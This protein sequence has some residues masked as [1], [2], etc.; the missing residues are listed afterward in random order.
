MGGDRA[1]AVVVEGAVRAAQ[2]ASG[3][4]QVLLFGPEARLRAELERHEAA[5]S[6]PIQIADAPE[7]IGMGEAPAAAVKNKR[8]SS[9]HLGLGAHQAGEADAFVSAG[10]TGAVM[11][12]S[13]FILGRL[14][15]V[16][17]PAVI[18]YYPTTRSFCIVLDV[19]TN[20]D[21]KPEHL[22]Q[23]AQMGSVYAEQVMKRERPAVALM[24]IGE[25]PGKGNE[26]VKAAFE[27]LQEEPGLN[28]RGN[29]EGRDL[30]HHAADVVVCDGFVGNVM[31]KL[32]ESMTTALTEMVRQEMERQR[33][34]E[35]ERAVVARVLGGVQKP[36]NYEEFGGAPLLGVGGNVLIGH[37][38]SSARAVERMVLAAAE[39]A[40]QDVA[41]SIA[42]ALC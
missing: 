14:P 17:R 33:L 10:N 40:Q 41:G 42:A 1:P 8:R 32:G 23:F 34:S 19:G 12:A 39:V 6:L 3:A 7:T 2:E 38:G 4:L 24:N 9:I 35:D 11:A 20:V 21:V 25:E 29:I 15:G 18:G 26:Q 5:A 28:F 36:F 13:L 16:A 27:L 31:L 22:V 37:G 30:M